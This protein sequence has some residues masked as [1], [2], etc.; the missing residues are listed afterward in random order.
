MKWSEIEKKYKDKWVLLDNVQ[1]DDN[2]DLIEGD[3]LFAHPDKN[4]VI[5]KMLELQPESSAIEFAGD[6]PEDIALFI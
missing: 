5:K 6:L 3:V 4:V 1:V 2:M